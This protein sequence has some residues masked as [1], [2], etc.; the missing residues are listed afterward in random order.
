MWIGKRNK[1]SG[2]GK[3]A[4]W[5]AAAGVLLATAWVYWGV[6]G[7]DFVGWD[8][9]AYITGN[10]RV[11]QWGWEYFKDYFRMQPKW[12]P[13]PNA[14]YTPLV[15]ATYAVEHRLAGL[16]PRVYHATNLVLHLLT[17]ALVGWVAGLLW[18]MRR[19]G[20]THAEARRRGGGGKKENHPTTQ[21]PNCQTSERSNGPTAKRS[22][23]TSGSW[24]VGVASAALFGLHPL[25]V[26]SVAWVTERKD[27]LS[28]VFFVL[29]AGL[30]LWAKK[31]GGLKSPGSTWLAAGSVLAMFLGVLSKQVAVTVP[32]CLVLCDWLVEGG[33]GWRGWWRR[34]WEKWAW[35]GVSGFGVWA[36]LHSHTLGG[37]FTGGMEFHP[38][39]NV[40]VAGRGVAQYVWTYVWPFRLSALYTLP[41]WEELPK[42]GYALCAAGV[43]A[44][45]GA[46]WRKRKR[47]AAAFWGWTFFL[48]A[49]APSSR[50][51]PVGI[52]F[53]SADRFFY[54]PGIG[55]L[56]ATAWGLRRAWE[57]GRGWRVAAGAVFAVLCVAWGG[58]SKERTKIWMN[59]DALWESMAAT[60]EDS[61][62]PLSGLGWGELY[63]KHSPSNAVEKAFA[64]LE[65]DA[66]DA[67]A[68]S[69][70]SEVAYQRGELNK[71]MKFAGYAEAAS[72]DVTRSRPRM[73]W[74]MVLQ[75]RE[76][77]AAALLESVL[78]KQPLSAYHWTQLGWTRWH[79]G[80][81]AGAAAALKRA[82]ELD[83]GARANA[84]AL[85]RAKDH[86]E[87]QRDG[88]AEGGK[89][90]TKGQKEYKEGGGRKEG[91]KAHAEARRRGDAEEEG[92][93]TQQTDERSN[94]QTV[95]R[96]NEPKW[97]DLSEVEKLLAGSGGWF[98][99]QYTA[100]QDEHLV[101]DRKT[102]AKEEEERLA[103]A[104]ERILPAWDAVM[105]DEEADMDARAWAVQIHRKTAVTLYNLACLA[106][107]EG[108]LDAA[109]EWLE[110][111]FA[112][113]EGLRENA[114]ED[115][116]LEALREGEA[117]GGTESTK[118][119]KGAEGFEVSGG[120]EEAGKVV[121]IQ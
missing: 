121:E 108:E 55:F 85:E 10:Y 38:V 23:G 68:L 3:A 109:K 11:Q 60:A 65:R 103:R 82:A 72:G 39:E 94:G 56:V 27:V 83:P 6:L 71:F 53:L 18:G 120:R 112:L 51:V 20:K 41:P 37:A 62:I 92:E 24:W 96:S 1:S 70:L 36:A 102:G 88:D 44:A 4:R 40:L 28:G 90:S 21:P 63:A 30:Y 91:E 105:E 73:A 16:D 104:M 2:G 99:L 106:C 119:Q 22:N 87:T 84:E 101:L 116:D 52:R 64:A 29:A 7:A 8:D 50:L 76:E 95:E 69:L 5:V 58:A 19:R 118:G 33:L 15:E 107:K 115:E 25:H 74:A 89:F 13:M 46:L 111:A 79:G 9:G 98:V 81:E 110:K 54:V 32:A 57:R 80:D 61:A 78:E 42:L 43:L 93:E 59:D 17:T 34:A 117:G 12:G 100:G 67:G 97:R 77:E 31:R 35:W 86:A 75:G 45:T 48:A 26:E 47:W 49:L 14:Q 113:D 66:M 114:A